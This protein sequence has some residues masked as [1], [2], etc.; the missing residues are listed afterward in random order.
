MSAQARHERLARVIDPALTAAGVDLEDIEIVP[1]GKRRLLR[2]VVDSDDGV[3]LDTVAD[4]SQD[5]SRL[6]DDSDVMGNGPY[7]LEVTSPGVDRPLVEPRHW[8]RSVGRLVRVTVP[9]EATSADVAPTQASGNEEE[10][11]ARVTAADSEGVTLDTDG[12]SRVCGYSDLG[13]GKV[14]VEFNRADG[15]TTGA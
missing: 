14:Q 13:R 10:I 8:R 9:R 5:V 4:V 7:V 3:D 11:L 6:L 15:P 2:L 12:H 1:A